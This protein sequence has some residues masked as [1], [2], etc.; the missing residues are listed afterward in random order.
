MKSLLYC[1]DFAFP[2]K[3]II[4]EGNDKRLILLFVP[5]L[6]FSIKFRLG[7]HLQNPGI[8]RSESDFQLK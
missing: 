8:S 4:N 6:I 5:V 1:L 3:D 2:L 7:E